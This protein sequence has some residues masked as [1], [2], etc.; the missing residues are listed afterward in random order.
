MR[1]KSFFR[2]AA[3]FTAVAASATIGTLQTAHAEPMRIGYWTSGV[4]LGFGAGLEAQKL[5]HPRG[6]D[7]VVIRFSDVNAR[8][9]T[10]ATHTI[11]FAFAA[12]ATAV[13]GQPTATP[14]SIGV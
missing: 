13:F 8:N 4:S 3:L 2:R 1:V 10:R 7:V 9:R 11:D 12:P 6:L 14:P 5:L